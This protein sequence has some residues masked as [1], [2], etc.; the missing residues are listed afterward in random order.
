MRNK[1]A[2]D[3]MGFLDLID[4]ER[5]NNNPMDNDSYVTP[6]G[7]DVDASTIPDLEDDEGWEDEERE[8]EG[9][10]RE[11]EAFH[12]ATQSYWS[13][14]VYPSCRSIFSDFVSRYYRDTR[15]RRDKTQLDQARW[16]A[17]LEEMTEAYTDYCYRKTTSASFDAETVDFESVAVQ[18][19]F[20][21]CR[22]E[23]IR[24]CIG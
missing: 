4:H 5:Y 23:A 2:R 24:P 6:S 10:R 14:C 3:N 18:D 17:Q 7:L 20:C 19:I 15:T 21:T 11:R 16:E 9:E 8:T 12:E 1:A 13:S 22:P